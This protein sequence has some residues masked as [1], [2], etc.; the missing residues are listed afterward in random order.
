MALSP[1]LKPGEIPTYNIKEEYRTLLMKS[2]SSCRGAEVFIW[3][4]RKTGQ[5]NFKMNKEQKFR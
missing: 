4:R 3:F 1:E 5:R 2:E